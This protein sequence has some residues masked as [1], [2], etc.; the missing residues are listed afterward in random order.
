MD[1]VGV[2]KVIWSEGSRTNHIYSEQL[3]KEVSGREKL[4]FLCADDTE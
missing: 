4:T 3:S 1:S 2:G